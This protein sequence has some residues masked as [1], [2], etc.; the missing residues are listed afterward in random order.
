[1]RAG[2]D[3]DAHLADWRRQGLRIGFTNGCF[4]ILHPGHVKVLTAARGACDRL[5]VGLNSDASVKRLKGEDRPVQDERARAEVLAALE[6]VDLVAIFE[7]DTPID[8]ITQIRPSVL[9]KGGDYTR[10]QVVGHEIVEAA[11]GEVVLVDILHGPQHDIA[12]RS[13]ARRQGVSARRSGI[14]VRSDAAATLARSRGLGDDG[15]H[16]RDPD[17][18]LAALVDV[19][20]RRSSYVVLAG[21][22]GADAR[23]QGLPAVAEASDLLA[24]DRAVRCWRSSARCGRTRHGARGSTRSVPTAKLLVLPVLFYH[25][26]RSA[27]GMWVFVAFLVS[28]TLLMVMS[29]IVLLYPGLSLKPVTDAERG[30]FVKNYIDQSQEFALCAVALA[31]PIISFLRAKKIGLALLLGAISLGFVVNMAFVI[32]SRTAMVTMPIM[33]AVFALLHLKWRT[34]LMIF[35]LAIIMTGLAWIASPQLRAQVRYLLQGISALQDRKRC[36]IDRN[37]AGVL[38]EILQFFEEAPVHRPR[39]GLDP[40]IVRAG[41]HR[42]APLLLPA[43]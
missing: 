35:C 42:R 25:F 32:V 22:D 3:L 27:R 29:W 34:S 40:G 1:M 28:C 20:G 39:H 5:I 24:A 19:A 37:A 21:R 33:L 36:D 26:E 8:L 17:R 12:G 41:R 23:L 11:G 16:V 38:A 10:E 13:R 7:E 4:D 43:R 18:A 6:A 31:Y 9:V 15:R 14:A 2:G 30:I